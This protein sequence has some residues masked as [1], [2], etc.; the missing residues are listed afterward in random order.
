M[1]TM[2]KL[3]PFKLQVTLA[4]CVFTSTE[5]AFH[6]SATAAHSPL[7]VKEQKEQVKELLGPQHFKMV[8]DVSF[9]IRT[10][11]ELIERHLPKRHRWKAAAIARTI[12][13][14]AHKNKLDPFF[15]VAVILTESS[16]NPDA[17]GGHGEL[18][19]MQILP[20]TGAWLAKTTGFKGK[21]DLR[22]PHINI[23]LGAAYLA[24]LRERFDRV[25][26]RYIA[27]YNMGAGNVS[28]L[29]ASK[30]EPRIYSNKVLKH[31]SNLYL[32]AQKNAR[33][34]GSARVASI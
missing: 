27:A 19:L 2:R 8:Q 9:D 30:I 13:I 23:Q 18:G 7:Q 12:L 26:N 21:V 22:N 1:E 5:L 10:L 34:K 3:T 4:L 6:D 28:R 20:K 11:S 25:G 17:R 15:L 24:Q 32:G 29:I 16:F 14:E 31:Y 33:D